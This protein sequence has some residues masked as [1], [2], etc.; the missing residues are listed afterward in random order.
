MDISAIDHILTTTR[1]VR[2]R[3]DLDRPVEP[4]LLERCIEI[5]LQAPSGSNRQGWHFVVI[6]DPAKRWDLAEIYRTSFAAYAAKPP[7]K[8]RPVQPDQEQGAAQALR[9]R[10]SAT[11]LAENMHKV[12]VM[13]IPCIEGRVE[14]AD[15][16]VQASLYGSILPATWSLMLALRARGLG[17]TWTTL[18]L[19]HEREAA[20]VLHIPTNVTQ[21]ALIPV[22]YFK[23]ADLRSANRLPARTVTHWNTWDAKP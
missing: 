15:L 18:H 21:V 10:M 2:K 11:Y 13:I 7:I 19:A 17:T 16:S 22:A 8:P 6:D 1:A 3:L 23:G 9:V 14:N 4:E 12:P 20:K 5:A